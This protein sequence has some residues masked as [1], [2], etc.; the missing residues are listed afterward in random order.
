VSLEHSPA[1][2]GKAESVTADPADPSLTLIEFCRLERM[3]RSAYY[4]MKDKPRHYY[5]G[6]SPRIPNQE[7]LDWRQRRVAADMAAAAASREQSKT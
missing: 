4:K 6:N 1:R 5:N 3:S 7:R 2:D